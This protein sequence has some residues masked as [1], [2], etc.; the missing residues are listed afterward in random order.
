MTEDTTIAEMLQAKEELELDMFHLVHEFEK[1]FGATV[2][3]GCSHVEGKR[4]NSHLIRVE[5][6][7]SFQPF[8][9]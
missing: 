9:T 2:T 1:R 3:L 7:L 8:N 4:G 5:A 6:H